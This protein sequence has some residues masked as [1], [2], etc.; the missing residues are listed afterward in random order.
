MS[1]DDVVIK[2]AVKWQDSKHGKSRRIGTS[3][4]KDRK[5]I[6]SGFTVIGDFAHERELQLSE[7]EGWGVSVRYIEW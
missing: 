7:F 1:G 2:Q 4:R 6:G 5:Y 3:L